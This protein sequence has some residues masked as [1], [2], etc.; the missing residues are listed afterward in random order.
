MQNEINPHYLKYPIPTKHIYYPYN[1][2][3]QSLPPT[4]YLP[5]FN[6]L[7]QKH[8]L[9]INTSKVDDLTLKDLSKETDVP[10]DFIR[11]YVNA[12]YYLSEQTFDKLKQKVKNLYF[13]KNGWDPENPLNVKLNFGKVSSEMAK[14]IIEE[15]KKINGLV[16]INFEEMRKIGSCDKC[17][18]RE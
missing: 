10:I 4:N 6:Q 12:N 1:S 5:P 3:L 9:S 17:S 7:P 2:S 11:N 13:G 16:K 14:N 8:I 18:V 15:M